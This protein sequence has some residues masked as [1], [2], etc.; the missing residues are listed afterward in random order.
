MGFYISGGH[1]K[2]FFVQ[3][4]KDSAFFRSS[5]LFFRAYRSDRARALALRLLRAGP[6]EPCWAG[7]RPWPVYTQPQEKPRFLL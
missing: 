1:T 2:E 6:A 7:M 3:L 4:R 5:R